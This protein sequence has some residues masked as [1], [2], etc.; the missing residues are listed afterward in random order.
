MREPEVLLTQPESFVEVVVFEVDGLRKC[1][2]GF[3]AVRVID[4]KQDIRLSP[5]GN[6]LFRV[7]HES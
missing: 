2:R 4:W 7:L 6:G 3:I 1:V 5:K